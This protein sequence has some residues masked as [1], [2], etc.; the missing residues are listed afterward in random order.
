MILKQVSLSDFRCFDTL[1][2][3]LHP[4][5]TVIV[6]ENAGGKTAILDAIAKG[7]SA[8]NSYF[9]SAEQRLEELPIT[10]DDLRRLP[11]TTTRRGKKVVQL[12]DNASVILQAANEDGTLTWGI[13]HSRTPESVPETF[14]GTESIKSRAIKIREAIHSGDEDVE[15]PV[16]AYYSVHRSH[17]NQEVKGRTHPPK[18]DYSRRLAALVD[19][20]APDLREFSE[21]VSWF[22]NAALDEL[23]WEKE[24][25]GA[26]DGH[27]NLLHYPGALPHL[28]KAITSVLGDRVSD[29]RWE[30]STGQITVDFKAEDG[31]TIP[32]TF[33]QLSQ[34]FSSILALVFDLTQRMVVAN[35]F[36]WSLDDHRD[37]SVVEGEGRP[38]GAPA[39][40]LIDEVDLHLHPSWQQRVLGDLMRAFPHTQFIVTTHS[41]QV[42][43]TVT[44]E[45]IRV[46][47]RDADGKWQAK[48]PSH[49]PFARESKD[50][51][52]YVMGVDPLPLE[53]EE[54][55]GFQEKLRSYERLVRQGGKE[56]GDARRLRSEIDSAGYEIPAADLAL[57]E[58]LGN[59]N[60]G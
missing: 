16:F 21:I 45:N 24:N 54:Q 17:A 48:H 40:V 56:S 34:G 51:L 19:S 15:V 33:E 52:A 46:L 22:K 37:G 50:A 53:T 60:Q 13:S 9:S 2:V 5:L 3:D 55:R 58:F 28:R 20:L 8:W 12:A 26:T 1:K 29:P 49:S 41:P 47:G 10:D 39:I 23:V 30:W 32:L 57:W 44:S 38:L 11:Q 36:Y 6:A 35:P 25:H 7:L 27:G 4:Q 43:T 42:L 14:V 18:I 31:Q 59:R